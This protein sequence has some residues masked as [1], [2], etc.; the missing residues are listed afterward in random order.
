MEQFIG[1]NKIY[2]R[3]KTLLTN[4]TKRMLKNLTKEC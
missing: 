4:L 1:D 3:T 2:K